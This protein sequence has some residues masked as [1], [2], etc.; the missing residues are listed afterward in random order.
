M[1][2]ACVIEDNPEIRMAI[3]KTLVK[4]GYTVRPCLGYQTTDQ[5]LTR[6]GFMDGR[7][8]PSIEEIGIKTLFPHETSVMDWRVRPYLTNPHSMPSLPLPDVVITNLYTST[9][10]HPAVSRGL[11]VLEVLKGKGVGLILSTSMIVPLED[12]KKAGGSSAE[13]VVK[14]GFERHPEDALAK[15]AQSIATAKSEARIT[16]MERAREGLKGLQG[17]HGIKFDAQENIRGN[18]GP[19]L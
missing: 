4:A 8:E 18:S 3:I 6:Y 7:Y 19:A 1:P 5:F 14:N 11:D 2:T 10:E 9:K 15:T 12:V 13:L 17:A 16:R